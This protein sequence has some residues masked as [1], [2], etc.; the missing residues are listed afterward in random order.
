MHSQCFISTITIHDRSLY[1]VDVWIINNVHSHC[2]SNNLS[3][4]QLTFLDIIETDFLRPPFLS[5]VSA[6]ILVCIPRCSSFWHTH[7]YLL[8]P[9]L[10]LS[11]LSCNNE[12]HMLNSNPLLFSWTFS[13]FAC[14][15][16]AFWNLN[17][18]LVALWYDSGFTTSICEQWGIILL[19]IN[20]LLCFSTSQ[21]VIISS[22]YFFHLENDEKRQWWTV[23]KMKMWP[24]ICDLDSLFLT[25]SSTIY[26]FCPRQ[27]AVT[28][29]LYFG[30]KSKSG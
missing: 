14:K 11:C 3:S 6:L 16:L 13:F 19:C 20:A 15:F 5:Q 30:I 7:Y 25:A 29:A 23:M 4:Q 26:T 28:T 21:P 17:S 1:T 10:C 12:R 27:R 9:L 22:C 2:M 18:S 24:R 8:Y